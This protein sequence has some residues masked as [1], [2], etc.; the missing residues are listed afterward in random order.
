MTGRLGRMAATAVAAA[1]LAVA[2]VVVVAVPA[3][4]AAT[5][6][7]Y[8]AYYVAGGDSWQYSQRGPAFEHPVDGEVQGWRFAVQT[9]VAQDLVPRQRPNFSELCGGT[10]AQPGQLRV[11]IVIDFGVAADAPP[12]QQPPSGVVTGCVRVPAGST[13]L[14]VL[15]AAVGAGN[16]R[17]GSGR[18]AGLVCGIS[19]YPKAE[20]AVV[21][22]PRPA[23]TTTAPGTAVDEAVGPQAPTAT[24]T[25]TPS[26]APSTPTGSR[27]SSG[28]PLSSASAASSAP[29]AAPQ[30]GAASGAPSTAATASSLADLPHRGGGFPVD[31]VIGGGLVVLL[32]AGVAWRT[33]A[34]HR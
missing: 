6:Y 34:A 15:D 17:I 8:W 12:G 14:D 23:A 11:G 25:P 27:S 19:G 22:A 9:R 16:V 28:P 10:P 7:R 29:A 1:A 30:S 26:A 24:T 33:W 31:A 20:C 5:S 21:A 3:A 18:D 2:S 4:Q 32:G 13:G